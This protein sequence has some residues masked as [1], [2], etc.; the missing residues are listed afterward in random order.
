MINLLAIFTG[1]GIGAV[2]RYLITQL[3]IKFAGTAYMFAGTFCANVIGCFLIGYIFGI[4]MQKAELIS[5]ALKLF[6][7]VGFLGGLTTFSTFSCEA[8]CFIK[9]GKI[10]NELIKGED[11]RKQ[12]FEK[13]IEV[14]TLLGGDLNN[15][16]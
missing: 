10:F 11:T 13:I 3:V 6:L 1:G 14:Q 8:F 4:S 2:C 5:P 16:I 15:V 12:F 9:D 7:T